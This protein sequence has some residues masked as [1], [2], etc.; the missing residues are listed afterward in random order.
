[1]HIEIE[2]E[3]GGLPP[4]DVND[5]FRPLD[6]RSADRTGMGLG[7]AFGKWGVK[8]N[9]GRIQARDLPERGCIFTVD[10]PRLGVRDPAPV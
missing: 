4:G 1:V 9:H 8:A 7:L 3:C 5:L 6:Q 2:D 10:L